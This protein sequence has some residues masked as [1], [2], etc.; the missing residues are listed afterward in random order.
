MR[1]NTTQKGLSKSKRDILAKE[2][3]VV[4]HKV[5]AAI[6]WVHAE[7]RTYFLGA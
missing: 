1:V 3:P 2:R 5:L 4:S 6:V 7:A